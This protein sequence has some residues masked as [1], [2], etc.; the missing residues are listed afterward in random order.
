MKPDHPTPHLTLTTHAPDETE[1]LGE[2]IGARLR[3]GDVLCLAGDLVGA[4]VL[5]KIVETW[6]NTEF[7]GGR[8]QRRVTKIA[9]IE[10]GMD[11]KETAAEQPTK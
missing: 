6:L 7:T 4:V 3:A 10:Q 2:R 9:V 11:P 1:R 5:R 8:H